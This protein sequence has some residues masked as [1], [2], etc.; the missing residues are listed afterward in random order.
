M[1]TI[2][3]QE[4]AMKFLHVLVVAGGLTA[5]ATGAFAAQTTGQA[6]ETV[7]QR[8]ANGEMNQQQFEQLIQFTGL[9]PDQAKTQTVDEIV[10]KRWEQD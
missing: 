1:A 6:K 7:G 8:L 3:I 9:T 2:R 5:A 10:A 4:I